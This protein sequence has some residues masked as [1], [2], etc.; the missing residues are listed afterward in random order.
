MKTGK[1]FDTIQKARIYHTLAQMSSSFS[2]I[3][4][5][6]EDLE[7]AGALTPRYKRLFQ[8]FT[9]EVQGDL[10]LQVLDRL[11]EM[12]WEDGKRGGRVRDRWEKYWKAPDDEK[13]ETQRAEKPRR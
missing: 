11:K 9:L 12:E 7:Q 6:C 3:I 1:T 8:A 4:R 10:N 2:S 5:H 13:A